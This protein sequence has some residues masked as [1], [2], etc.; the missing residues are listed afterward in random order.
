MK[1]QILAQLNKIA[2]ELDVVGLHSE[3]NSLT[4]VMRRLAEENSV[5][6]NDD[7]TLT[8]HEA[9]AKYLKDDRYDNDAL[10][11][12]LLRRNIVMPGDPRSIKNKMSDYYGLS[13]PNMADGAFKD[14]VIYH[15]QNGNIFGRRGSNAVEAMKQ[16]EEKIKRYLLALRGLKKKSYDP[17]F[18]YEIVRDN[19]EY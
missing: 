5:D 11:E 15:D 14:V 2:N 16:A 3:A 18:A 19:R 7:T 9:L 6:D 12:S 13:A 8:F 17:D 1:K 10:M 4:V